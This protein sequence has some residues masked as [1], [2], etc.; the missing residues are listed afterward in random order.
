MTVPLFFKSALLIAAVTMVIN[1]LRTIADAPGQPQYYEWRVYHT[2]SVE[3]WQRVNEYWQNAAV[4]AYVFTLS[5]LQNP[6]P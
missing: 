4:P 1:P 5:N 3:Q 6:R 2:Q